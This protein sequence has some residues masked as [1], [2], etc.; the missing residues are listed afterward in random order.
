MAQ[1]KLSSPLFPLHPNC[2]F[3]RAVRP[4]VKWP[5]TLARHAT[6][7]HPASLLTHSLSLYIFLS[8]DESRLPLLFFSSLAL[9]LDA[10]ICTES[11]SLLLTWDLIFHALGFTEAPPTAGGLLFNRLFSSSLFPGSFVCYVR[12][13]IFSLLLLLFIDLLGTNPTADT[14]VGSS[15][16][17]GCWITNSR[18]KMRFRHQPY[19]SSS[20]NN[21]NSRPITITAINVASSSTSSS[22]IQNKRNLSHKASCRAHS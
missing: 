2:K 22:S 20:N 16:T 14:T 5:S 10:L 8:L 3:R 12:C 19:N 1:L 9:G 11:P 6:S 15:M 4:G 13:F 18:R 7:P 17:E 21:I